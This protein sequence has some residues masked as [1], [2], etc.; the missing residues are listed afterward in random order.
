MAKIKTQ[1]WYV[2][3]DGYTCWFHGLSASERKMEIRKHGAIVRFTPTNQETEPKGSFLLGAP[4]LT[5]TTR[6]LLWEGAL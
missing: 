1:G 6:F 4:W 5:A 2:F 3:A